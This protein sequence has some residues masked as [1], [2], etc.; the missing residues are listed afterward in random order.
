MCASDFAIG[1]IVGQRQE[2]VFHVFY[3]AIKV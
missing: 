1:A 3:Y 2:E